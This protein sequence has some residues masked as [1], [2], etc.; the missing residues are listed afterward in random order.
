MTPALRAKLKAAAKTLAVAAPD[1]AKGKGKALEAATLFA[2]AAKLNG[3]SP[4]GVV[5]RDHKGRRLRGRFRLRGGPGHL[6]SP[7]SPGP[8]PTYFDVRTGGKRFELHNSLEMLGASGVEHEMDVAAI[9][10]TDAFEARIGSLGILDGPPIVGI[11]LKQFAAS[12]TL[13]KNVVRALLACVV[14]F[15]PTWPLNEIYLGDHRGVRRLEPSPR[16]PHQ[17]WL[18]TS[19]NLTAPSIALADAYALRAVDGLTISSLEDAAADMAG[20]LIR[21]ARR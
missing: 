18:L 2:L 21:E 1:I 16:S 17:F 10:M 8:Q 5:A 20:R 14:D 7:S 12:A 3:A 11:E 13:A 15:I 4:G 9:W 19:A 6:P